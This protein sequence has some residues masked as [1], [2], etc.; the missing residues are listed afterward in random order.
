MSF[1]GLKIQHY[2]VFKYLG[3][4]GMGDVYAAYDER[5]DRKVALKVIR[6]EHRLKPEVKAR[7]LREARVLSAL[8]HPHICRIY[9]LIDNRDS[10]ILVLELIE[11]QSLGSVLGPEADAAVDRMKIAEQVA[12]ALAAAHEQGVVHRDLKPDNVMLTPS[13]DVKVL[14]F[15]LARRTRGEGGAGRARPAAAWPAATRGGQ[16]AGPD[17]AETPLETQ[18][19]RFVGTPAYMSPEQILGETVTTASDMYCLGVL[20]Q[21]LF[22]GKPAYDTGSLPATLVKVSRA[23]T[24][25]IEGIDPDLAALIER[26]QSAAPA[27]RPPAA[28]VC[29]RLRWIRAKPQRRRHGLLRAAVM[30]FLVLT[31][32][33][34]TF[35][36]LRLGQAAE[37]A[38]LAA[39]RANHEAERANLEA[40]S[41]KQVSEFLVDLFELSDPDGGQ[42]PRSRAGDA[43]AITAREILA[44][45]AERISSELAHQP[46]IRAR[47]M[48]TIGEI[49]RKLGLFEEAL[50]LATEALETRREVLGDDHAEVAE[51]QAHLANLY[52][53]LGRFDDAAPLYESSIR[54]REERDGSA[55]IELAQ[56]LNG[57][58]I[59]HWNRGD[60]QTAEALHLRALE[61]REEALGPHHPDVAT[62]LDNLAIVYKDQLLLDRA[63]PLFRRSLEIREQVLGPDHNRVAASLNNLGV[64]YLDQEKHEQARPLYERALAIWRHTLGPEHHAVGVALVNLATIHEALGDPVQAR[65]LN[66]RALA[67]LEAALG[68]EHPYVGYALAGRGSNLLTEGRHAEAEAPLARSLAILEKS[69]GAEHVDVGR[70]LKQLA[71]ALAAGGEAS[72]AQDLLERSRRILTKTLGADHPEVTAGLAPA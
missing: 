13:G 14:D 48:G 37:R 3:N 67:I 60:Y 68:S 7:L 19:G 49:Y 51:S 42:T 27:R 72:R 57:L 61:I 26:L 43:S 66:D 50:P 44:G 25:P 71:R 65:V 56:S 5:L 58:A 15:G 40:A 34:L 41:S 47:L 39:E 64:L 30:A 69:L 18:H 28:D 52:W 2:Q 1:V 23:D 29:E 8:E 11:G 21:E 35:Q 63:E 17:P 62:S 32:V 6:R 9:D 16:E 55:S 70:G 24:V 31:S 45:G 59:I 53:Q 36:T 12:A 22:T 38:N 4:G 20:L 54:V 33:A 46:L 10:D